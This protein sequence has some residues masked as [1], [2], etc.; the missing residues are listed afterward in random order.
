MPVENELQV[1]PRFRKTATTN[2]EQPVESALWLLRHMADH[3]GLADLGDT[4]MLDYGCGV[5]FTEAFINHAVPVKRYA[6][7]DVDREMI[8]FLRANVSDPRF[9]YFHIDAHNELYNPGGEVLTGETK[10]PIDGRTFDLICLFSV[11]THLAPHDYSTVLKLMRRYVKPDGRLFYTVFIDELTEGRHGL[12]DKWADALRGDVSEEMADYLARS[13]EL[14]RPGAI[15]TFKDLH[16]SNPLQWAVYSD[17][18]ARELTEDAGW[19]VID[20][21]T[22]DRYIQH[23]FV[24]APG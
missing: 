5:K 3:L 13:P 18:Y 19:E 1:P 17:R 7:V 23:H 4:E 16:P 24:C 11:F 14:G 15:E 20:L 12:M 10:L 22:P 9:E 6:G 21:S 2:K 8:E